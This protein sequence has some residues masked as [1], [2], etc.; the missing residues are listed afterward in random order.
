MNVGTLSSL[1]NI[2]AYIKTHK[3]ATQVCQRPIVSDD[4]P[5][6]T[7]PAEFLVGAKLFIVRGADKAVLTELRSNT[8][9]INHL[10]ILKAA[11]TR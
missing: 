10:L 6:A 2:A 8:G 11:L 7:T 5:R 9:P 4:Y 1:Q 3:R